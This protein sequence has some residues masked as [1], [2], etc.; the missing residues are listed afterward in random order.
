MT[1][2]QQ[3]DIKD[4]YMNRMEYYESKGLSYNNAHYSSMERCVQLFG[5]RLMTEFNQ[6]YKLPI[7]IKNK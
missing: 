4:L 6:K 7:N 1:H 2:K 3:N 5:N